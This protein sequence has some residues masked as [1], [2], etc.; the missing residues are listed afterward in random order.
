MGT[1]ETLEYEQDDEK[2]SITRFKM[3]VALEVYK[4]DKTLS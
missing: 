4:A 1:G 3:R 2:E